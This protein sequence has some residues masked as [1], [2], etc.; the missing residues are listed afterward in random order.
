MIGFRIEGQRPLGG[1]ITVSGSKNSALKILAATLLTSEPCIIQNVPRIE[2]VFRLLELLESLGAK[3]VWSDSHTVRVEAKAINPANISRDIIGRL[4]A[5]VILM[6]ALLAR[7]DEVS[8]PGPGGDQIGAR[9]LDAHLTAFRA[10]GVE[11][12]ETTGTYK[13]RARPR[14]DL[15]FTMPEFSVTATENAILASVLSSGNQTIIRCAA[16][17]P[18]V[19]DLCWFLQSLGAQISG[20]GLHTLTIRGVATLHPT[21]DYTVMPDPVE[22]GTLLCLAAAARSEV[23]IKNFPIFLY[24]EL[25]KF[26]EANVNF[27]MLDRRSFHGSSYE[28][29]DIVTH[30]TTELRAVRRV[31]G[32]PYPGFHDDLL[33]P[34]TVLLTQATGTSL[35]H[36]WMY[37]GRLKFVEELNKMGADIFISD[38]HRCLV[39]GPRSLYGS[40]ITN[41]DIRTGA[42]LFIAAIVA[43]GTS[44]VAPAYQLDRGY[45][46]LDQRLNRLGAKIERYEF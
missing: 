5:S 38:P 37:E 11:V 40:H 26:R 43:S 29:V 1:E 45:E 6:G 17:D 25:Q 10:L 31:H 19:Q 28:V 36:D 24:S 32:M 33:P 13:L 18:S 41:Y 44:T 12:V 27:A 39:T 15:D 46:A 16:A 30:P 14:G 4:R 34:F 7:S 42:S 9:P 20:V 8:L 3:A 21:I 23:R 35:V 2:D 22:A